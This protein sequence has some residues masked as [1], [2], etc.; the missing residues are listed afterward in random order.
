MGGADLAPPNWLALVAKHPLRPPAGFAR[1]GFLARRFIGRRRGLRRRW[2][3]RLRTRRRREALAGAEI[4][5]GLANG[6]T[7]LRLLRLLLLHSHYR[8]CGRYRRRRH[9]GRTAALVF[10]EGPHFRYLEGLHLRTWRRF[11]NVA[12][13][14]VRLA[15][16]AFLL[17]TL[18][19]IR[20]AFA[21]APVAAAATASAPAAA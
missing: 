7:A 14:N 17:D 8:L 1:R 11:G 16:A 4:R 3:G 5:R 6:G 20:G 21:I 2:W 19:A 18:L 12:V 9:G 10:A 15:H 13:Q